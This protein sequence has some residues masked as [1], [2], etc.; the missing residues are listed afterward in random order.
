[1]SVLSDI[2]SLNGL[3]R[4]LTD[5]KEWCSVT[6]ACWVC[7]VFCVH[8][9]AGVHSRYMQTVELWGQFWGRAESDQARCLRSQRKIM[10][11]LQY[12]RWYYLSKAVPRMQTEDFMH[13]SRKVSFAAWRACCQRPL[14]SPNWKK[15]K[16]NPTKT[17]KQQVTHPKPQVSNK[18]QSCAHALCDG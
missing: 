7:V 16:K 15:K 3:L 2:S 6:S 8:K 1:M 10:Y 17:P 13:I 9:R 12:V 4:N 11:L 5:R 14:K 18:T